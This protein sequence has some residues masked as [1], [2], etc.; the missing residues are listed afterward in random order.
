MGVKRKDKQICSYEHAPGDAL[1]GH[2]EV[3]AEVEA[4]T[5]FLQLAGAHEGGEVQPR[6]GGGWIFGS[7]VGVCMSLVGWLVG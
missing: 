7:L 3:G 2:D 1:H 5:P 6:L 4:L